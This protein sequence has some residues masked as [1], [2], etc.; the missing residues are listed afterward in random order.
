MVKPT[1]DTT[2][3]TYEILC[4]VQPDTHPS[5]IFY[6]DNPLTHAFSLLLFHLILVSAITRIAR[7]IL[8]PLKQ[9]NIVSQII[10]G[11]IVGPSF[12]GRS[13]W[14]HRYLKPEAAQFLMSN[15]GV[16]GF[17]FFV[18]VY[19]VKMD[20]SLMRKSGKM[21]I[22]IALTSIT[23]PTIAVFIIGVYLRK[24]MD[25]ELGS[26]SSIGVLAG[27][28][29]ITAFHVLYHILKE[30]NLLNSDVG[31][32]ALATALISDAFGI[33]SVIVFEASKQGET[34]SEN[35]LW[36]LMSIVVIFTILLGCFRPIM[37]WINH[38]TP[39]GQQVDQSLVVGILLGV[40][41]MA[42]ITDM[43][44]IAIVNGPLWLGLAIPDGPG[45]GATLVQKCETIMNEFLMPFSFILIG[46]HTDFFALASFDWK[47]LKP[48]FLMVITGYLLKFFVTWM[49]TM[50]WRMPFRDGLTFSL[51]MSLR[52]QIEYIL[53]VHLMDKKILNVPEFTMLVTVTTALTATLTPLVSILYD[54]T[55]PYILNQRR[56]LQHNPPSEELRI[57]LCILDIESTNGLIHL[58]DVTNP[59]STN[60]ISV[61]CLRLFELSGRATPLLIDHT[62]QEAPQIYKWTPIINALRSY[63]QIKQEFMKIQFFTGVAPK[64]SMF[65]TICELSLEQEASLIILP[66]INRG[67]YYHGV[68]RTLNSQVLDNAPCSIAILV[69]KGLLGTSVPTTGNSMRHSRHRF[70]VL[71]FGG[72]DARE[73]LVYADRMV[74][75]E[76]VSLMVIRFLSYNNVGDN[77]MEKKLDDGIVTSFWVKNERNQRVAYKEVVVKNGEET[78]GAIHDMNDG[79]FDLLIV[80][81]KH[82]INPNILTGLSEWSE[83]DELGLIGDYVSSHDFIG[84]ASVLVVQQQVL[85]G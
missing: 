8:K 5:G 84:S 11:V 4:Q 9:P 45:L 2:F 14:Y 51:I 1:K 32:F 23:I 29:G 22:S 41:V 7:F 67:F 16:M 19:G 85:R 42:F 68:R 66:F 65:Q 60:P 70:A 58:L 25:K 38:K 30:L 79:S 20:P 15:L 73:A 77:E 31:Q 39:E 59:T 18:F 37:L 43:F 28:L 35:A 54:P 3:S 13:K 40:F 83:S 17:M 52:G 50:Y 74:A 26:I 34:K 46:H 63:Q 56:N 44:G 80:G 69:D 10:G 27:Y 71:F 64:Q 24:M 21:H 6:G 36:Y 61:S 62:I 49:A 72:A 47:N 76:E 33:L 57:M 12:L 55:R 48:L 82:G 53:F 78:I 81:R 75:N